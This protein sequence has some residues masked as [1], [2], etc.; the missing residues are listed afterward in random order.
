MRNVRGKSRFT[1]AQRHG[2][3]VIA[4][5]GLFTVVQRDRLW[6]VTI[7][8]PSPV[9]HRAD[10]LVGK[11]DPNI[12]EAEALVAI[13]GLGERRSHD[14]VLFRKKTDANGKPIIYHE[15][16]DLMQV[17]G[18]GPV[19]S[20]QMGPYLIFPKAPEESAGSMRSDQDVSLQGDR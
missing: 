5:F 11:L 19:L 14:I 18:I 13:P 4:A 9:G 20:K 12:A 16:K 15:L 2:L 6:M 7:G 10:D 17:R 3:L 1:P 8:D